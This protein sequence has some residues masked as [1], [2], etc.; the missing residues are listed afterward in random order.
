MKTILLMLIR[1]YQALAPTLLRLLPAGPVG[2]CC[3]F[4]PSCSHFTAQAIERFGA[5]R[6]M[7]LGIKRVARCHPLHQGGL[8]PVPE[9]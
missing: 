8:D 7:W 9:R 2:G 5:G 1:L 6:G 3:R 4:H